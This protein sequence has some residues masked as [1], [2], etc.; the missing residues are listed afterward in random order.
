MYESPNKLGPVKSSK[1][2]LL[3]T[4]KR[5]FSSPMSQLSSP[6]HE[7]MDVNIDDDVD[8]EDDPEDAKITT[9]SGDPK[10]GVMS[11]YMFYVEDGNALK[12]AKLKRRRITLNN[13]FL[14]RHSG[15]HHE[16]VEKVRYPVRSINKVVKV[17]SNP[18]I[19][20]SKLFELELQI[21]GKACAF[22]CDTEEA[23]DEWFTAFEVYVYKNRLTKAMA[24]GRF[25]I[26]AKNID[27]K[28]V[29]DSVATFKLHYNSYFSMMYQYR[30]FSIT[31]SGVD[32]TNVTDVSKLLI[33]ESLAGGYSD[34]LL[35]VLTMLLRIPA[36]S[37]VMWDAAAVG[38]KILTLLQESK[39]SSEAGVD[40]T[41]ITALAERSFCDIAVQD[42]LRLKS[43]ESE[44]YKEMSALAHFA[45]D[46]EK[47]VVK[48]QSRVESLERALKVTYHCN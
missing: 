12:S 6:V 44:S 29:N 8:S 18:L 35:K 36:E 46:A 28:T 41:S 22:G 13:Q 23:R 9:T 47:E 34:K 2:G 25:A 1:S 37:G 21:D 48:L 27:I 42:I 33:A 30:D 38:F 10:S 5:Q 4:F 7:K 40:N 15:F 17:T 24:T 3:S 26:Y 14:I 43:E 19:N 39:I 20:N 11:G 45:V 16:F 31:S 32:L